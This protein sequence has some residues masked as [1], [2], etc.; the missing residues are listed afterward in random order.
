MPLGVACGIPL[1]YELVLLMRWDS[2]FFG[3]HPRNIEFLHG[4]ITAP[5]VHGDASH[6]LNNL[7]AF[8]VLSALLFL[9]YNDLAKKVFILS[10]LF[11][12]IFMFLF[13][14]GEYVHIGASGVVYAFIFFLI[15]SGIIHRNRKTLVVTLI[16]T[17]FYGS[18]VWGL[19]P[20]QRGVSWD[21][22]LSGAVVGFLLALLFYKKLHKSIPHD[23]KPDWYYDDEMGED[24]Y[25]KFE[26]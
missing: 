14:R 12:G 20:L 24:E 1:F 6:L 18:A 9:V 15:T 2:G 3:I 22:H 21:G 7:M 13:A 16:V 10:W 26:E 25:K 4:I 23:P 11:T 17:L 5:L 19:F 8:L